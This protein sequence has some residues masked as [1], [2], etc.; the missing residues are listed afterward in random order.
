VP[1]AEAGSR[2]GCTS[3][4]NCSRLSAQALASGML[5]RILDA[6]RVITL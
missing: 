2:T 6:A 1:L 4:Q 3:P 5:N